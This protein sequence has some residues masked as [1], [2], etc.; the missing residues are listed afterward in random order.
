M[1]LKGFKETD[2]NF[3]NEFQRIVNGDHSNPHHFLGLHPDHKQEKKCIC[4]YRP[5]ACEIFLE[6][7]GKILSAQKIH[8]AGFFET[9]VL[10]DID[11]S[12]YRIYHQNGLLAHDPYAFPPTWGEIDS[13][14]FNQGTHYQIYEVM[15]AHKITHQNIEGISFAVWAPSATRVSVIGDFNFWDG[16]V[17]PMRIM[18]TSGVWELFVPG[19][20]QG[21]RYKFEIKTSKGELLIKT[22]PYAHSGEIRPATASVITD[23]NA[24]NWEDQYWI[25]RRDNQQNIC[26]PLNIYELHIGSWKIFKDHD[27]NFRTIAIALT[28]Y[29]IEMGYTHVE[30]LP[31]KEH[32]LDE[33]WGYQVSGFYAVTSRYGSPEDFQFFVNY[34][35]QHNIGVIL[36]WVPGHFPKDSAF[37]ACFDGTCLY[38][39]VDSKQADHPHW[40]TL[41]F[42]YGRKEVMNFLIGSALFW[43]DKMHMDGLRVDAVAS[44]IYLDYGREGKEWIPN[45]YGGKE[46]LEAIEFIKHLNSIIH[47]RFPGVMMI[48]EESTAFSGV[49]HSVE[50]GGLG[51]DYKWNMGWMHDTL[52]YFQQDPICRRYHHKALT[53]GLLYAFSEKFILPLSHDE[54]VH[55]KKSLI[56]K[57]PGNYW[58]KFANLRLLLSYM[59]CQP[60]KKMVFMGGEW[61][62]FNEWWV[63]EEAH[64]HLLQYPSHKK[65]QRMVKEINH[66][67]LQHP[68]LW[69]GDCENSGFQW[70]DFSDVDLSIISYQ[71]KGKSDSD[72]LCIHNFTPVYHC[73]YFLKFHGFSYLEEVFNTDE[74]KYG[75]SGKLNDEVIGVKD[76]KGNTVGCYLQL[77]PLATSILKIIY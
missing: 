68:S 45:I 57:M 5:G 58:E 36:D 9:I 71:R 11:F 10:N 60:G 18:D 37:L 12:D 6:I 16:R 67:Y 52:N 55:G 15:G 1:R 20:K 43:I 44:M 66:F 35:H 3:F 77:P 7:R 70:I 34:L 4:L 69:E 14:L 53:F 23:M 30:L 46:N 26:K 38:E 50:S 41:I 54:V 21:D 59:I 8:D 76:E 39:H 65:L 28:D 63:K 64:W 75:G 25:E 73:K 17:N 61:G 33:S 51:F 19:L 49:T 27:S 72:L 47:K 24:F 62:Q 32:P 42:N 31:I 22:D 48:A 40:H 74:E 2:R 13:Y 56:S 29:C